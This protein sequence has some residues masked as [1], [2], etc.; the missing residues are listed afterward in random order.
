MDSP[1]SL[2][3]DLPLTAGIATLVCH[4]GVFHDVIGVEELASR[5]GVPR[6]DKFLRALDDLKRQGRVVVE[7]GFA[8]LPDLADQLALKASKIATSRQ[9]IYA[10]WR[11]LQKIGRSP[12]VEFAGISGSLAA[13]NPVG[14]WNDPLDLDVFLITRPQCIWPC[15]LYFG[16]RRHL[17]WRESQPALCVNYM[18]DASQLTIINQNFYTATEVR[19]LI[20]VAG[21]ETYRRFLQANR[22]V[23]YYYPGLSSAFGPAA[24][25]SGAPMSGRVALRVLNRCSFVLY[26]L[27]RSIRWLRLDILRNL[28]PKPDRHRAM[29]PKLSAH[30]YGGYQASIQRKFSRLAGTWFPELLSATLID[31]LYPDE[32]SA[33]I[34]R[35]DNDVV[36][37]LLNAGYGPEFSRYA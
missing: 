7:D 35:G 29:G 2:W 13:G 12:L 33:R 6:D 23:D 19:N 27:L 1:Q 21:M 5:L 3:S 26:T 37:V 16:I 34:K 4:A 15:R 36:A 32:L 9:L 8:G 28:A 10:R 24:V 11:L 14:D 30:I 25:P 17:F 20:P 18:M 22:W 31:K